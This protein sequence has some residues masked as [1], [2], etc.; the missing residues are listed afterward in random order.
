MK[1]IMV[2]AKIALQIPSPRLQPQLK[3]LSK[4]LLLPLQLLN[5]LQAPPLVNT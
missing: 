3:L 2:G 5:P 4:Q 1:L